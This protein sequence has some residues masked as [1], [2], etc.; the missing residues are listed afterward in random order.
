MQ[1]THFTDLGLRVLMYLG[2]LTEPRAVTIAEISERFGESRNHLM[3]V[4][5]FMAQQGWLI[6]TRGKGGGLALARLPSDYRLGQLI[7]ALEACDELVDC[8]RPP[9]FLRGRCQLKRL[10][11][12]AMEAL[13]ASLD[14]HTL[15]DALSRKTEGALVSLQQLHLQRAETLKR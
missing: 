3:K 5:N 15:G 2:A 6:T 9:C 10:L 13:Y 12:Q 1:L 14:A 4:V 8:E 7:R 11:D